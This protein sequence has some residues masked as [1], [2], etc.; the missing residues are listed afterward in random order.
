MTENKKPLHVVELRAENFKRL[1]AVTIR[2]DGNMVILGG[3]NSQGKTSVID[4]LEAAL[5]GTRSIPVDPI[6]HGARK[7]RIVVDLGEIVVERTFDAKGT[8]LVVRTADGVPQKSPQRLLDELYSKVTFDP[9][10]FARA[11]PKKQ[12]VILREA[13]GVDF[14]ALDGKRLALYE[15]RRDVNRDV[16]SARARLESSVIHTGAPK[17]EVSVADLSES[18]AAAQ[19]QIA[20]NDEERENLRRARADLEERER[21]LKEQ[22]RALARLREE[23]AQMEA[24]NKETLA[25]TEEAKART[26]ALAAEVEALDDPDTKPILEQIRTAEETNAKVRQNQKHQELVSALRDL[27]SKSSSLTEQIADIDA[28]KARILSESKFPIDG[29]GFDDELGP[30]LNGVPLA[31]SGQAERLRLS[32]AIAAALNPRIK[33]MLVREAAYLDEDGL[34]QLA[35]FADEHDCQLIVERVGK[36]DESAIIIEDG[37]VLEQAGAAE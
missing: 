7:A 11:E 23:L 31:Q 33:V 1:S 21:T 28:E 12:D 24:L 20:K 19:A 8:K 27:E 26:D 29:L 2:P 34:K 30:T 13:I 35:A 6:R 9:L 4:S 18:L 25:D 5:G 14:T 3:K 16:N 15:E 37:T 22:G 32:V 17:A 36:G 10:E